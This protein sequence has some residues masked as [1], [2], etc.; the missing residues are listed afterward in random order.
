MGDLPDRALL[1]IEEVAIHFDVTTR[2]VYIWI[3]AKKLK[4]LPTPGGGLRIPREEVL[5]FETRDGTGSVM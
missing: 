5:A 4:A 1:R 3:K 2:T